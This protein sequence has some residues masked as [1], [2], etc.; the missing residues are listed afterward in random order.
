MTEAERRALLAV[1]D[2]GTV[3]RAASALG[4]SHYTVERQLE[5]ARAR[6]NVT[7]TIEAVRLVLIDPAG[8]DGV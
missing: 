5:S 2:H 8:S 3:K 6:L 4:K 1:L 7:T